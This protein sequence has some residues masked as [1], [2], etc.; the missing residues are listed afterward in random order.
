[1][2]VVVLL[3]CVVARVRYPDRHDALRSLRVRAVDGL[4]AAHTWR[5]VVWM[6]LARAETRAHGVC[7]ARNGICGAP[8]DLIRRILPAHEPP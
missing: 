6:V 1:M 4:R 5:F 3:R 7:A 2:Q 8:Y